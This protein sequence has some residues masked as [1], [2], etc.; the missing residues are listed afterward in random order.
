MPASPIRFETPSGK[1]L[2]SQLASLK[3][4]ITKNAKRADQWEPNGLYP[5]RDHWTPRQHF[6]AWAQGTL[7]GFLKNSAATIYVSSE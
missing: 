6:D 3:R 4:Y 7:A 2:E 1:T 5:N